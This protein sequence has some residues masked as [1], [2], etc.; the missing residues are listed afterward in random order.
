M[1]IVLYDIGRD[2]EFVAHRFKALPQ[3]TGID[4][5]RGRASSQADEFV[6]NA[7]LS[8]DDD[9]DPTLSGCAS[10]DLDNATDLP[11][12]ADGRAA[13]LQ[14]AQRECLHAKMVGASATPFQEKAGRAAARTAVPLMLLSRPLAVEAGRECLATT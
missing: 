7:R 5:F 10:D 14:D 11:S 13:K 2:L 3:R 1:E 12:V 4:G 6:R 9:Y 8:R